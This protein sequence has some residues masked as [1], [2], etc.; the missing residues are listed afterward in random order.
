M[1]QMVGEEE[2]KMP[3][4]FL[5]DARFKEMEEDEDLISEEKYADL[6]TDAK[7]SYEEVDVYEEGTGKGYGKRYRRRSP[8]EVN[9]M[10]KGG[11]MED[12]EKSEDVE[13]A[14]EKAED[15]GDMADMFD[16]EEAALE[17]ALL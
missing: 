5:T 9:S 6:D 3:S 11:H 2:E 4:I 8:L 7:D 14:E 12:E 13:D 16:T 15:G 1:M 10:R 17:R